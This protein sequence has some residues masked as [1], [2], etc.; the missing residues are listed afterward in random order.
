M[1]NSNQPIPTYN[2]TISSALIVVNIMDGGQISC[3][4]YC[5]KSNALMFTVCKNTAVI[6]EKSTSPM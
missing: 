6:S 2:K 3:V 4:I 5:R 1:G